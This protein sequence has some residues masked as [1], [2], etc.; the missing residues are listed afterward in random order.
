MLH[1]RPL[2]EPAPDGYGLDRHPH[3]LAAAKASFII[4]AQHPYVARWDS[5]RADRGRCACPRVTVQQV[6]RMSYWVALFVA[7][8]PEERSVSRD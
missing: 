7:M 5:E 1:K 2:I 6:E 3:R 8:A 4:S